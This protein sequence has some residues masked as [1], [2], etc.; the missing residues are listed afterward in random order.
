MVMI[1][2]IYDFLQKYKSCRVIL[3]IL[4]NVHSERIL[5]KVQKHTFLRGK[6]CT[7]TQKTNCIP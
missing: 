6:A 4:T 1:K 5:F 3:K 2:L 7:K